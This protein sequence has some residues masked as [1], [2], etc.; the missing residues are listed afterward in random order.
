[1]SRFERQ[2]QLVRVVEVT[3]AKLADPALELPLDLLERLQRAL[4]ASHEANVTR[5]LAMSVRARAVDKVGVEA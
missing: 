3:L 2:E 1:M 5:L 4:V